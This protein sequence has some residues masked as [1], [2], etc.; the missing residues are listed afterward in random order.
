[1]G[2]SLFWWWVGP[3]VVVVRCGYG[4]PPGAGLRADREGSELVEREHPLREV[5]GDVLD[6]GE[7]GVPVG[8][9]GLLPRLGPLEGDVVPVQDPPQPFP[10]DLDRVG[11]VHGEV[12][13]ELADTP[14]GERPPQRFGAGPGR[15]DDELLVVATDLAGTAT[16]PL[17][18]QAGHAHLVEPVDDLPDRIL[19]RL[20]EAG[21]GRAPCCRRRT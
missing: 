3:S 15:R 11:G 17:R 18:V 20:H 2:V 1:M 21:D 9:G 4:R 5:P 13:G 6:A 10:P 12:V 19:V 14:P 7:F 8:V 16:R